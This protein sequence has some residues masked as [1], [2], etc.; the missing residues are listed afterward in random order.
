MSADA[1]PIRVRDLTMAFG[2]FVVQRDL[3]FDVQRGGIFVIMGPSGCGKSTLLK[4][5]VGLMRP[6][7]GQVLYGDESFWEA[8]AERRR[9]IMRGIG[10]L[11]QSGAL[12]SSLTLAE[13]ITLPLAELG[14]VPAAD[15]LELARLKLRLVGLRGFEDHYP[16][17]ISGGMRKRAALARAIALEPEILYLDEPSA[18]L[19]PVSS[20][21]LD[22]LIIELRDGLGVTLVVVTHELASIFAI[23]D[24]SVFLDT[25]AR[26]MLA[27]GS[28]RRLLEES[29]EP[30][31][32]EFLSR[33]EGRPR[34]AARA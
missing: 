8:D 26:T 13:N 27:R 25:D 28:P 5:M 29:E 23:A 22:R 18:G 7:R 2:A 1:P 30:R 3:S 21:L 9:E 33:G 4:H 12:W 16:F 19:D 15:A 11:Y 17:E 31:V 24:D 6:A 20:H 10:V 34:G 14:D 32:V